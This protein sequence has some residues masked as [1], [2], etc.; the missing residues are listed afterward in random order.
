VLTD[1]H[2][3]L[4]P[5]DLGASADEYF[6]EPNVERYLEAAREAGVEELGVSEHVYRFTDALDLW[7][8]ELWRSNAVDD[9]AA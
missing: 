8:H 5:D 9:L 7:D 4:R 6:T 2:V 3:H 1:Y